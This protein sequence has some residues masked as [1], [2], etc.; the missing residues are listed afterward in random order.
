MNTQ[1]IILS[2]IEAQKAAIQLAIKH[3]TKI[4]VWDKGKVIELD[5]AKTSE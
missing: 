2:L 3:G 4:V 5:P 1:Q